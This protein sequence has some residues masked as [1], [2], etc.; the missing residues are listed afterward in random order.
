MLKKNSI[1]LA[2]FVVL[3][4]VGIV[5][6]ARWYDRPLS[7]EQISLPTVLPSTPT[8]LPSPTAPQLPA[9]VNLV[10]P[11]TAQAPHANWDEVHEEFCEEASLLMAM[12][13][14]KKQDIP[15]AEFA[16]QNLQKIK[17]FEEKRFGFYKD[18]T[19]E[20]VAAIAREYYKYNQ[21][22]IIENPTVDDIQQAVAAGKVVLVPAAGRL[23]GNPNFRPPGPLYHM[24]VIKGYTVDQKFIANDPGTRHGADFMYN[25]E[26][27]MNAIHDWR[28]DRQIEL[29]SKVVLIVG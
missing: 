14:V 29:G 26:V 16:E 2:T 22:R 4:F 21:T 10:V 15:N 24:L 11:F 5:G 12:S 25:E 8:P 13:Y 20:E 19:I 27:L 23:L 9:N 28:S 18:T 17:T 3:L 1:I 6:W 7:V